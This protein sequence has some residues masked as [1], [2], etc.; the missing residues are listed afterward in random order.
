MRN[1]KAVG[2]TN[3]TAPRF[4][5]RYGKGFLYLGLVVHRSKRNR[6]PERRGSI[7]DRAVEKFGVRLSVRVEDN[8]YPRDTG[9]D[10]LQQLEPFTDDRGTDAAK[11]CDVA[12]G[13]GEALNHAQPDGILHE[14][15]HDRYRV[16]LLLH[17]VDRR[18]GACEDCVRR[19]ADQL[20]RIG[21]EER[22][23]TRGKP[24]VDPDVL[25]FDPSETPQRLR[26]GRYTFLS[27]LV[28]F[29]E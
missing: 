16:R 5:S 4:M 1:G 28:V 13:P 20:R 25:T 27:S 19:Q 29:G 17:R 24:V 23:L 22:W 11:P 21:L 26:K 9:R 14:H 7:F 15:K 2:Q 3:H 6:H 8:G 12:A 10:V 18:R